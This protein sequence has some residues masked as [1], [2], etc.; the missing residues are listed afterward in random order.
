LIVHFDLAEEKNKW[1][2]RG[3][4]RS[5]TQRIRKG[6]A[7]KKKNWVYDLQRRFLKPWSEKTPQ[8][9][10]PRNR[11]KAALKKRKKKKREVRASEAQLKGGKKKKGKPSGWGKRRFL[12]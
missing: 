10:G 3:G 7:K 4:D 8:I 11:W 9:N 2:G 6:R 5:Q 12:I 1:V